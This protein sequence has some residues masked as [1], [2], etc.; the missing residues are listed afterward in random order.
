MLRISANG[1]RGMG[2]TSCFMEARSKTL[3]PSTLTYNTNGKE[4]EKRKQGRKR[5]Y[6]RTER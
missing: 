4:K 2:D 3:N 6:G 1:S 5:N